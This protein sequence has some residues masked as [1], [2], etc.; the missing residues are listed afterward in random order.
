MMGL[1]SCGEALTLWYLMLGEVLFLTGR[2]REIG[3]GHVMLFARK[4]EIYSTNSTTVCTFCT[5]VPY[6]GPSH[7]R[8]MAR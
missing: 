5:N 1:P 6:I 2:G 3:R 4:D 7:E 8:E